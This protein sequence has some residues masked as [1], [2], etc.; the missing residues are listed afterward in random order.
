MIEG[1]D[2]AA[3]RKNDSNNT[4]TEICYTKGQMKPNDETETGYFVTLTSFTQWF[5]ADTWLQ[6]IFWRKLFS[7]LASTK[8]DKILN[9]WFH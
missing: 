5:L 9:I 1:K 3:T 8:A 2:S 7:I 4:L 6:G